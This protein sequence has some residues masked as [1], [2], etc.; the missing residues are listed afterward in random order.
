MFI[1]LCQPFRSFYFVVK[2]RKEMLLIEKTQWEAIVSKVR[3]L[4]LKVSILK[5][6]CV[7]QPQYY[8]NKELCKVLGVE[9]RLI[10]KYRERAR[11]ARLFK[12]W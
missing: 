7:A 10:Q 11:I 6:K 2:D 4:T 9:E 12:N 8:N 1:L 5:D 3:D